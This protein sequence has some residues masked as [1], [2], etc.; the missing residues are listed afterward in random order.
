MALPQI[1]VASFGEKAEPPRRQ[2]RQGGAKQSCPVVVPR[3]RAPIPAGQG[4]AQAN[5]EAGVSFGGG[6]LT[7]KDTKVTKVGQAFLP[8]HRVGGLN[9]QGRQGEVLKC[10]SSKVLKCGGGW[11]ARFGGYTYSRILIPTLNGYTYSTGLLDGRA[12]G[13]EGIETR[14]CWGYRWGEGVPAEPQSGV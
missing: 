3:R 12:G 10:G 11:R 13:S 6:E 9:R 2:G 8:V 5:R 4:A 1:L 14:R 7:T